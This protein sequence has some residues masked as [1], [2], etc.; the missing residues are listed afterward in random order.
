MNIAH[1]YCNI[2][3]MWVSMIDPFCQPLTAMLTY[4]ISLLVWP[5]LSIFNHLCHPKPYAMARV[6]RVPVAALVP[7]PAASGEGSSCSPPLFCG[8]S[9]YQQRHL[10]GS[11]IELQLS[12][13]LLIYS[14]LVI[15]YSF[16]SRTFINYLIHVLRN[17]LSTVKRV[18]GSY[19]I[20]HQHPSRKLQQLW[21]NKYC[22]KTVL[23][24][25]IAVWLL[26]LTCNT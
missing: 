20:R 14:Y 23:D 11:S 6:I 12:N 16:D 21:S 18:V 1:V 2:F 13:Y 24:H 19:C 5:S 8:E 4:I 10:F 22:I 9:V 3:W 25:Q 15:N 7:L 17:R 26:E